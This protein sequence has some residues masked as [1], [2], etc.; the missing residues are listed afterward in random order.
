M[1]LQLDT[2]SLGLNAAGSSAATA[3]ARSS[4][5]SQ[6]QSGVTGDTASLS[7]TSSLLNQAA[8]DRAARI[9]HL[10]SAVRD[11]SYD[12]PSIAVSRAIVSEALS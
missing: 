12:V 9:A 10:T 5:G 1:R 8:L 11:G 7:G 2:S 4:N 3:T 6:N